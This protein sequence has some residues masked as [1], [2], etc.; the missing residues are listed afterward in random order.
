MCWWDHFAYHVLGDLGGGAYL[1]VGGGS[2]GRGRLPCVGGITL[3]TMRWWDHF[4][5]HV[6]GGIT[7]ACHALGGITAHMFNSTVH[8]LF[9]WRAV[10]FLAT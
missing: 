9:V 7:W 10:I 3:R 5:Y 2:F 6:L 4:A 8:P 1:V